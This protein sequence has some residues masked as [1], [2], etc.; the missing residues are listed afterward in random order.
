MQLKEVL[1]RLQIIQIDVL[2]QL[3]KS[4][5]SNGSEILASP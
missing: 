4:N 2:D 3:K 5:N 1:L